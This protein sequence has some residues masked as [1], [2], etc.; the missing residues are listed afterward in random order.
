MAVT[1]TT[2]AGINCWQFSGVVTQSEITTAWAGLIVNNEYVPGRSIYLDN[3][4]DLSAV[5]GGI[6]V[7][8]NIGVGAFVLHTGRDLVKTTFRNWH[9]RRTLGLSVTNRSNSVYTWDGTTLT[10][11]SSSTTNTDGLS[12]S[13]GSITYAVT[14]NSGVGDSRY[15]DELALASLDG[16]LVT[17]S[18]FTEQEMQPDIR[19]VRELKGVNFV[20]CFG[21][22]QTAGSGTR[23][24]VWRCYQ[25]TMHPTQ[26]PIRAFVGSNLCY[27]DSIVRR[28]DA[29]V[30]TNLVDAYGST[31]GSPTNILVI[32]NWRDES[33]FGVSKTSLSLGSWIAQNT[34][35]GM[36]LRRLQF[37]G[38]GTSGTVKVYDSRSTTTPARSTFTGTA[39]SDYLAAT[40]GTTTDANGRVQIVAMGADVNS[41]GAIT[42]YSNQRYTFQAFG[43]RV[44]VTAID[45]T[46]GGDNDLSAYAPILPVTQTGLVRTQSAINAATTITDFQKLLEELHVLA[47]GLSG[48]QSYAGANGGN[49]FDLVNGVLTTSF[50]SVTV[51]ATAASKISYNGT[52][53]ALTIKSSTLASNSAVSQWANSGG[54]I[55]TANGATITGTFT[56]SVGTR[57]NIKELT[58]RAISTYVT[59]NGTAV[60]GSTVN[61]TFVAGWQAFATSRTITVQPTD[62][63]R[64]VAGYWGS[65]P[66][67][68]N[69]LGSEIAKF[70][71]A[72]ESEP[73][74][75]TTISTVNRDAI[76]G[77]ILT[78]VNG[79][80]G[81]IEGT[82]NQTL[83]AYT[84]TEVIS[85]I[86]YDIV[87]TSYQVFAACAAA[88]SVAIYGISSG[89]LVFYSPSYKLRMAD[90][91]SGGAAITP[92][93][94]GY[95][96][97]IVTYYYN[98][99]TGVAS[100]VTLLNAAGAKLETA[101]WTQATASLSDSDK[102]AIAAATK[103]QLEASTVLAKEATTAAVKAKTDNLPASPA[104]VGSAM[105]L[106]VAYDAAKT[107]LA[108]TAYTAPDNTSI[109]AIKAKTDKLQFNAQDHVSVN[110]HQLQAA[111]V[112][113][114]QD[115]LA[116]SANVA[117]AQTAIID[118]VNANETKIDALQ[119][120]ATGIKTKTDTLV[121][122]PTLVQIEASTVL[123]KEATLASKS[124][125]ASVTALGNPIQAGAVVDANIIKVNDVFV[126]GSGTKADPWGPV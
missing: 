75:D 85:S 19:G 90:T 14:G 4:C 110:V 84:P 79:T 55:T 20:R 69:C 51:D 66:L 74:V 40:T 92:N 99:A 59:I 118:Q 48:A 44:S 115:G 72:F 89:K 38:V 11:P 33:W 42:R 45:V 108:S 95:S 122:G 60:G 112:T 80:T 100:P 71:L 124:S 114:I 28:N 47:I 87:M 103:A 13:G 125:Q 76:A 81:N 109:T 43:Y 12:M 91:A 53:N 22:P 96:I 77:S 94:T 93:A 97:P 61:S 23:V 68:V 119:T 7:N 78:V 86:A 29:A 63:V 8:I 1:S 36:V 123:A 35:R 54:A 117:A 73:G 37:V 30:T 56:D 64:I 21:F 3:T 34:F 50:A 111:A 101:P 65:K 26:R 104:A 10:V 67:L 62:N 116:T 27:V 24:I 52:T 16:A 121:N 120:T 25:N 58:G 102:A 107:A 2:I 113:S 88:N 9:F 6:F 46:A 70:T 98:V 106:T 82:I 41:T 83:A 31:S 5:Q 18:A 15:L 57:V 17:S 49:L 32:N 39:D 105:T 126:D